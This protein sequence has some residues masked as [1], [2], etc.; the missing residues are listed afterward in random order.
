[1]KKKIKWILIG[2]VLLTVGVQAAL[3]SG[4]KSALRTKTSEAEK[5]DAKIKGITTASVQK[6]KLKDAQIGNLKVQI[7]KIKG[8]APEVRVE[9]VTSWR[10]KEV[11]VPYEVLVEVPGPMRE[12]GA[13]EC[14]VL[15]DL[16]APRLWVSG[17]QA[18]LRSE[19]GTLFA[20]GEV[21]VHM[22]RHPEGESREILRAPWE[23]DL[24]SMVEGLK[25]ETRGWR[26]DMF[27]GLTSDPGWAMG[28]K[29]QSRK[30]LGYWAMY[31]RNFNTNKIYFDD[32]VVEE[33]NQVFMGGLSYTL[34]RP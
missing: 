3:L 6:L 9:T 4:Y 33:S 31:T 25:P 19:A 21:S 29:W 5:L 20:V 26:L 27:A 23:A 28:L 24:T 32:A 10:T 30:R 11:S 12:S 22:R 16:P 15:H 7:T 2:A 8:I 14:P 18:T 17:N 13:V 1:M 34:G